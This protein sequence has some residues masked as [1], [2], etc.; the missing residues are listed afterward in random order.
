MT[1]APSLAQS[2][3]LAPSLCVHFLLRVRNMAGSLQQIGRMGQ[4]L[5]TKIGPSFK[6]GSA[7]AI[8]PVEQVARAFPLC[9]YKSTSLLSGKLMFFFLPFYHCS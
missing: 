8:L 9:G 4:S 6:G 2:H 5:S 3:R 7:L 1:H